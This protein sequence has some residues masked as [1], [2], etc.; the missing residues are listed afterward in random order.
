MLCTMYGADNYFIFR[1][2]CG[3]FRDEGKKN[4][5]TR[6][7]SVHSREAEN[8]LKLRIPKCRTGNYANALRRYITQRERAAAACVFVEDSDNAE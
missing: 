8:T 3:W 7:Y 1:I 6:N 2:V 4:H 5:S